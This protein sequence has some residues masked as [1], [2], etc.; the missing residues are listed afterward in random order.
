MGSI[1]A[2]I[3]RNR[4]LV[5]ALAVVLL[6]LG[7]YAAGLHNGN[8]KAEARQLALQNELTNQAN[9]I[10]Q[11]VEA[12]RQMVISIQADKFDKV[13]TEYVKYVKDPHAKCVFDSRRVQLKAAAVEAANS[14]S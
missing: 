5:E 1:I 10:I 3:V 12:L 2:A 7:C 13:Q 4:W 6:A 14:G 8:A 9:A 11:R